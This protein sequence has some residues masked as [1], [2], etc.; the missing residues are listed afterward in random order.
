METASSLSRDQ[1]SAQ[2]KLRTR[3]LAQNMA[4]FVKDELERLRGKVSGRKNA[5]RDYEMLLETLRVEAATTPTDAMSRTTLLKWTVKR[6]EDKHPEMTQHY[7]QTMQ[8][9]CRLL[10]AQQLLEFQV[11]SYR[12]FVFDSL[13]RCIESG[14]SSRDYPKVI[15]QVLDSYLPKPVEPAPLPEPAEPEPT[16][17]P[18]ISEP[19]SALPRL[20]LLNDGRE[21]DW[22]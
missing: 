1:A 6:L 22:Q 20:K 11:P 8:A 10:Q 9:K 14:S 18:V 21:I 17:V 16:P 2:Y 12:R 19:P 13:E 15:T 7:N 3:A 5:E 4:R